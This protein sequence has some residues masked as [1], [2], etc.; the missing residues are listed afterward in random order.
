MLALLGSA[1]LIVISACT[2]SAASPPR[3]APRA[4]NFSSIPAACSLVSKA[5]LQ[6]LKVS[7]KAEPQSAQRESGVTQEAC[8]W[9]FGP[10]DG[11]G[12]RGLTVIV[13]LFTSGPGQEAARS[14][15]QENVSNQ[16]Q[17][18]DERGHTVAGL[19]D[20][21]VVNH[22][23]RGALGSSQVNARDRNVVVTVE[24]EG[25]GPLKLS[26]A[27]SGALTATRAVLQ[28]LSAS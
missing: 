27:D 26:V 3:I 9:G 25:F 5:T 28:A 23:T 16:S 7:T 10:G 12:R 11:S 17:A 2:S 21:A 6:S 19:A 8:S 15:F 18:D 4:S 20:G 1:A 22:V 14:G 13:D 24:Y